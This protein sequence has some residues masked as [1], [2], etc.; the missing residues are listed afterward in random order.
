MASPEK[1]IYHSLFIV[2]VLILSAFKWHDFSLPYFW[3]ELGVYSQAADYQFHHAMSM[4]PESVPPVLSRG[5][6][7][8]FTF[9]T[10]CAMRVFGDNVFSAHLF[11]FSI[12]L[13]LLLAVYLKVSKYFNPLIGF[14]SAFILAIQPLFLAQS[15]MVLPEILLA[16]LIFLSLCSYYEN[17]FSQFAIFASLAILTK[18][19]AIVIPSAVLIYSFARW[20]ITRIRP[21][22]LSF[23]AFLL[24]CFPYFI[25][26]LFLF[27]QKQQN[28]WY[29][30]PYHLE[31]V[32]YSLSE[33]IQQFKLYAIFIF[34]DQGRYAL[35]IILAI[36]LLTSILLHR[37]QGRTFLLILMVP[38]VLFLIMHALVSIF[39]ARYVMIVLVVFSILAA[40]SLVSLF[41]NK[42]L[43]FVSIT[44]L[45]FI[46]SRHLD[47]GWFHYDTDL[48]YR[49]GVTVVQ[50][51]VNYTV[52]QMKSGDHVYA[53]F[54]AY[55]AFCF[56]EGG[57]L[58]NRKI[59]M[60]HV[61]NYYLLT[62]DPPGDEFHY[63]TLK[64]QMNFIRKFD[65][66]PYHVSAYWMQQLAPKP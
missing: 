22:A 40:V 28:G 50:Q 64:Y 6:P 59:L 52:S 58:P 43:I 15:G 32:S 4:M 47:D 24:T 13:L 14:L 60:E 21:D 20:M 39:M 7:L 57:Y 2:T 55:F 8:F 35:S 34:K 19:S 53:N 61:G 41:P 11:C 38:A 46:S 26:A 54:P 25:F 10:A 56:P 42:W 29:F 31:V 66:G 18:E 12:S 17:K 51:A 62:C 65:N 63:D 45:L 5:H 3:D 48:G 9:I 16:L 23:K 36:S 1:K 49:R 33:F 30:F 27:I 44:A 37:S